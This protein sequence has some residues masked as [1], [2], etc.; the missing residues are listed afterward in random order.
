MRIA[1][2]SCQEKVLTYR[3]MFVLMSYFRIAKKVT[4][5]F[6]YLIKV[7]QAHCEYLFMIFN[8]TC[9]YIKGHLKLGST[10]PI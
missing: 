5:D 1:E 6:S 8:Q 2:N 7:L 9:H 4:W 10:D 3:K